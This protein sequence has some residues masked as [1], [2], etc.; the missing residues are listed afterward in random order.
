M[1]CIGRQGHHQIYPSTPHRTSHGEGPRIAA[2]RQVRN[3][4][5]RQVAVT[6]IDSTTVRVMVVRTFNRRDHFGES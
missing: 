1:K 3:E 2:L 4:E 5:D 6:A